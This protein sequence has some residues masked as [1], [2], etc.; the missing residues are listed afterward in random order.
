MA[1]NDDRPK[2]KGVPDL[3]GSGFLLR[4]GLRRDKANYVTSIVRI[5]QELTHLRKLIG[6]PD[7][8]EEIIVL[9]EF[10]ED[11]VHYMYQLEDEQQNP[12]P[13]GVA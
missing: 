13:K 5:R 1:T 8:L 6:D 2:P 10:M 12:P 7:V 3:T 4:R 9:T 11:S